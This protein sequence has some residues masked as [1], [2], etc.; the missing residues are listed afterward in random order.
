MLK[1]KDGLEDV[2]LRIPR[3]LFS[4]WPSLIS[5]LKDLGYSESQEGIKIWKMLF[6]EFDEFMVIFRI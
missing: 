6:E 5:K 2:V 1:R 3:W 4:A